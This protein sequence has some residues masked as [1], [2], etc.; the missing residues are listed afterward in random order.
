MW[1]STWD[2]P[3]FST[4]AILRKQ[5]MECYRKDWIARRIADERSGGFLWEI[6]NLMIVPIKRN[7][8]QSVHCGIH[9]NTPLFP[10]G[11]RQCNPTNGWNRN[12]IH[13][14]IVPLDYTKHA[15]RRLDDLFINKTTCAYIPVWIV[16]DMQAF[17]FYRS[18]NRNTN[19]YLLRVWHVA[20]RGK[21]GSIG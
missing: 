5:T 20:A 12:R 6:V 1:S 15:I 14:T 21:N 16:H 18:Q 9:S 17:G 11:R 3:V 7:N 2:E 4:T 10:N 13:V 8:Q 19:T